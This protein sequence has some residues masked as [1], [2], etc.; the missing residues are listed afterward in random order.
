[1]DKL[2]LYPITC[3][4]TLTKPEKQRLLAQKIVLCKE[5]SDNKDY[6]EKAVVNPSRIK[7]VLEEINQLCKYLIEN[8]KR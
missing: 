2:G 3:L 1:M 8:G 4:T 7:G 6:L 5:I